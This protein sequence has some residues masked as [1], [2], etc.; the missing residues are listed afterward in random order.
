MKF[1]LI[2]LMVF[3]FYGSIAQSIDYNQIITPENNAGADNIEEMLVRLAWE[4]HPDNEVY[5]RNINIAEKSISATRWSWLKN[6]KASYNLN[7]F[8]MGTNPE[9]WDP[10]TPE[11]RVFAF[12][13]YNIGFGLS[14]GDIFITPINVKIAKEEARVA[15]EELNARKLQLR[16]KVLEQ[17]YN[18]Q[19]AQQLLQI[20]VEENEE[21]YANYQLISEKFKNGDASLGE[22]NKITALYNT[23]R[24]GLARQEAQFKIE[25][26]RL[27]SYIGVKLEAIIQE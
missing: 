9:I 27:E 16:A 24:A 6:L 4:N 20:R 7:E 13:R 1:A 15:E 11:S 21:T 10:A 19:L 5:R 2:T 17:Y 25:K 23:N 3:H 14:L 22:Y 12:P 8:T 26:A 18:Y